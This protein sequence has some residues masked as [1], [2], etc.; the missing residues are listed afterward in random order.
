MPAGGSGSLANE[1]DFAGQQTDATGLQYLRAR[2]YDPGSGVFLSRD[3][4]ARLPGW[5]GHPFAYSG[6]RP[7]GSIDPSGFDECSWRDPWECFKDAIGFETATICGIYLGPVGGWMCE[8]APGRISRSAIETCVFLG[9]CLTGTTWEVNG[10]RFW[11]GKAGQ[12]EAWRHY[13]SMGQS[14]YASTN[15]LHR[16]KRKF[17]VGADEDLTFDSN[18]NVYRTATVKTTDPN[19]NVKSERF[20]QKLGN[21]FDDSFGSG[22]K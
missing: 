22:T 16:L 8:Q 9:W 14:E 6:S 4:L 10:I 13:K 21:I 18:G 3:P 17:K 12:K 15:K 7:T 5:D 11:D 2:Y 19:G 20:Y 1:F